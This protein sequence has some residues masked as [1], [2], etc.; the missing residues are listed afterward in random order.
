VG[1]TGGALNLRGVPVDVL[2]DSPDYVKLLNKLAEKQVGRAKGA[3]DRALV[4]DVFFA[5]TE[6]GVVPKFV[7]ADVDIV[8]KL[9]EIAG[10]NPNKIGGFEELLRQYRSTGF[11]VTIE[12][13]TIT[14]IP[15]E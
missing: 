14:V 9:A 13:R 1:E 7:T 3:A 11:K 4:A 2:R 12:G 15:V 5:G 6:P 10:L 8:N